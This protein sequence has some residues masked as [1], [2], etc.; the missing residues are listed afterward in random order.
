MSPATIQEAIT[1]QR[2][3]HHWSAV[4]RIARTDNARLAAQRLSAGHYARARELT[5]VGKA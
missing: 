4:S 2:W 1:A 5:G 3:A